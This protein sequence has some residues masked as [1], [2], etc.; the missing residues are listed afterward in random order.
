MRVDWI[1]IIFVVPLAA[2][3]LWAV[4]KPSDV[5]A[6]LQRKNNLRVL[7]SSELLVRVIGAGTLL[8]AAIIGMN[9]LGL[10]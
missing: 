7:P 1:G 10:A 3:S 4:I 9:S 8:L 5:L 2:A 6:Y